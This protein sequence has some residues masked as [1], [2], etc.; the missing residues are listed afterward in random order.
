M[1]RW[2]WR[3][4]SAHLGCSILRWRALCCTWPTSC[5]I[6]EGTPLRPLPVQPFIQG[7]TYFCIAMPKKDAV[8]LVALMSAVQVT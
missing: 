1:H 6:L 2:R 4:S 7:S 5:V 8:H 3:P